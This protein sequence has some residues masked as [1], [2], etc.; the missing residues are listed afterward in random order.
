MTILK[1]V[2]AILA[3]L[4]FV[5]ALSAFEHHCSRKFGYRFFTRTTFT[6]TL[7]SCALVAVGYHWHTTAAAAY[8]P[9]LNGLLLAGGGAVILIGIACLNIVRTNWLYGIVGSIIQLPLFVSLTYAGWPFLL[10]G[11]VA[12]IFAS[13]AAIR[14]RTTTETVSYEPHRFW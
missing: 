6:L 1:I 2:S 11:I 3:L 12:Y 8:A 4:A 14:T 7:I 9:A 13:G 10:L 5:V